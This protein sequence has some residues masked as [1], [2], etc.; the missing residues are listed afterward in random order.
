MT[1]RSRRHHR[2]E[3]LWRRDHR[4]VGHANIVGTQFHPEKSQPLRCLLGN[5]LN[6]S[7]DVFPAIDLKG[8][9]CVRL[10]PARWNRQP[11]FNDDPAAQ[12]RL[13]AVRVFNGS[14]VSISMARSRAKRQ[15]EAIKRSATRSTF[16]SSWAAASGHGSGRGWLA[17]WNQPGHPR[18]CCLTDPDSS[19]NA[20]QQ[21][22]GDRVGPMPRAARSPPGMGGGLRAYPVE[23]G[24]RFEDAGFAAIPIYRHNARSA[25]GSCDRDRRPR[26]RAFDSGDC[27]RA[28]SA[29]LPTS[30][31]GRRQ[32]VQ[33]RGVVV[34]AR[35]LY[36]G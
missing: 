6:G 21:F 19:K 30:T 13:F 12:A 28:E 25:R 29:L 8:G 26:P 4:A 17:G 35:P 24:K 9:K 20:A 34:R 22:P 7:R 14:T 2:D 27:P 23:L 11:F 32:C 18:H 36:A 33:Y 16:R 31:H 5:F 15:W 10:K 1:F 3:R